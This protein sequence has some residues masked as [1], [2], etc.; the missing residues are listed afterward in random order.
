MKNLLF[1]LSLLG[2]ISSFADYSSQIEQE[3]HRAPVFDV[4]LAQRIV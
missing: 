3:H 1:V 2:P 4:V